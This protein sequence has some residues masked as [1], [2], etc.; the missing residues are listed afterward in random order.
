MRCRECGLEL[1]ARD[2]LR[3]GAYQCPECGTIHHTAS[4]S[5]VSPSPWR[6]KRRRGAGI[7]GVFTRKLWVLPVWGWTAIVLAV[8]IALVLIFV[9]NWTREDLSDTN[10]PAA[11]DVPIN[12][13]LPG[14]DGTL[15]DGTSGE[16]AESPISEP[17]SEAPEAS[18]HTNITV[19]NL[20]VSFDWAM[21]YLKYESTLSL[22]SSETNAAGETVQTYRFDDWLD[23]SLTL[24]SATSNIRY[25][26]ASVADGE[27]GENDQRMRHAFVSLLYAFDNGLTA[28]AA[29]REVNGM[30]EDNVRTYGTNTFVAKISHSEFAGY[31]LEINGKL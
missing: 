13:D 1:D 22:V 26:T 4:S 3:S 16:A 17:V 14:T 21:S 8:V 27:N 24:D 12:E 7:G 18:G 5:R 15:D 28:T 29:T 6:R 31:T 20:V 23:I 11:Q 10:M 30:L 19:D 9:P 25:A 2:Q